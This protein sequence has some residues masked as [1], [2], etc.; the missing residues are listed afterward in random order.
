MY[1]ISHKWSILHW[2]WHQNLA[3]GSKGHCCTEMRT[4]REKEKKRYS[5]EK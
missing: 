3:E 4:V 5:K 2:H 1:N